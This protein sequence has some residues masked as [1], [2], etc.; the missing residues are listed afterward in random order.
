[1]RFVDR[2]GVRWRVG[3]RYLPW[4]PRAHPFLARH[5]DAITDF[6]DPVSAVVNTVLMV[7]VL[8]FAVR[9]A[10]SWTFALLLTPFTVVGRVVL[11]RPWPVVASRAGGVLET[12]EYAESWRAAG[13]LMRRVRSETDAYARGPGE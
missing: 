5:G 12:V 10:L 7:L 9:L 1:M 6:D 11:R 2:Q 4:R 13:R 8:P 3:R